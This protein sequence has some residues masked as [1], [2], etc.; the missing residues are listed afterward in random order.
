MS[1]DQMTLVRGTLDILV[2]KALWQEARHGY[3]VAKWVRQTTDGALEIEDGALYTSLHRMQK[4][5]WIEAEWGFSGNNRRAKYYQL[6]GAGREQLREAAGDW[7]R[8]VEA[9]SKVLD[10]GGT[11]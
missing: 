1:G 2:L 5:G 9:V 10:S 8:Y 11:P 3:D 6:T 7:A 4:R